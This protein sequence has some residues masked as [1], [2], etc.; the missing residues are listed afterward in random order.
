MSRL[1]RF[2]REQGVLGQ[3]PSPVEAPAREASPA[4]APAPLRPTPPSLTAEQQAWL[5]PGIIWFHSMELDDDLVAPGVRELEVLR[6][7]ADIAFKHGVGGKSVLDIGAWD[8]FF[9]FEAE[10]RGA[11]DVLATDHFCWSGSGWG[12]KDGFDYV[13]HLRRSKVRSRDID[14]FSLAPQ[15]LGT[16]DVVLFLGVLYH[17]KNPYG[18][19]EHAAAM[20]SDLLVVETE[21]FANFDETP[22]M[23]YYYGDELGGD[24]TN[25]FAPNTTC[26]QLMLKEI[27]LS[28]TEVTPHPYSAVDNGRMRHFVHAW[29]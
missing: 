24:P 3:K 26:L 17:L 19:L 6:A 23:R 2:L 9:S 20:T 22:L 28:R 16:F 12:T 14:V 4:F 21:T 25:F 11:R 29:R 15:E 27:G 5:P 13:H 18:G 1:S 10:R 8:G 7:E